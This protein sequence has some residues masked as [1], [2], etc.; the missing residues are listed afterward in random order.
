M[1]EGLIPEAG[2]IVEFVV[3]GKELAKEAFGAAL[4]NLKEQLSQA[5]VMALDLLKGV[6]DV[7]KKATPGGGLEGQGDEQIN[8][9]Y[10]TEKTV[11]LFGGMTPRYN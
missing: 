4:E 3:M 6:D 1:S 2:E 8:Y 7:I 5:K 10:D 11:S 9:K